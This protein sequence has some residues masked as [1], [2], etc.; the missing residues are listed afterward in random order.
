MVKV[1]QSPLSG[2]WSSPSRSSSP[3]ESTRSWSECIP[4]SWSGTQPL[5]FKL[6]SSLSSL[7]LGEGCLALDA[8]E[9]LPGVLRVKPGGKRFAACKNFFNFCEKQINIRTVAWRLRLHSHYNIT[10]QPTLTFL[11][12]FKKYTRQCTSRH[13]MAKELI[14]FIFLR[15]T[16][17][18]LTRAQQSTVVGTASHTVEILLSTEDTTDPQVPCC[19]EPVGGVGE[20]G[21]CHDHDEGDK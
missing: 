10:Q 7:L 3:R 12:L 9:L 19:L 11:Y 5:I 6:K 13:L 4:C 18:K 1:L 2:S 15:N 17:V 14:H 21:R 8:S 16:N 20:Y